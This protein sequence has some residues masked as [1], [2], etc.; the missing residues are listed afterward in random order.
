MNPIR[1]FI[2][3]LESSS[4]GT[5][6]VYFREKFPDMI[7]EDF[8]GPFGTRMDKLNHLLSEKSD[9]IL[10]GSSYGGLMAAV[11]AFKNEPKVR[12]LILLAPALNLEE[13]KPYLERSLHIPAMVYHG[14]RDDVVPPESVHEIARKVFKNLQHSLVE[15]DHS[16]HDTFGGMDWDRLLTITN[17]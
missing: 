9:L 8:P 3:G 4:Q 12:K 15:D 2:H 17:A 7:I 11:Y 6:G 1:V 14:R 10:V 16:L 13:F 5:K